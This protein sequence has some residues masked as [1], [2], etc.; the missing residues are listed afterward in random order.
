[1]YEDEP[2]QAMDRLFLAV[3]CKLGFYG[4][5]ANLLRKSG[6]R[7]A[8][9]FSAGCFDVVYIDGDHT[10][11][12]VM[13]DLRGWFGKVRSG[14]IL[15]GD[16]FNWPSVRSAVMDFM[17]DKNLAVIGHSSAG[18]PQPEKWSVVIP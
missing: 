13:G 17:T 14:G 12:G 10:Y 2:Q 7:A 15:C 6:A 4:G 16:D 1:M 18:A 3:N 8:A 9:Q 11:D 5:R